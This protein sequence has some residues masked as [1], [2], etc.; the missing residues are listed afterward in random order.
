MILKILTNWK[1]DVIGFSWESN[2][3]AAVLYNIDLIC[4]TDA[5]VDEN[6]W[7]EESTGGE[8]DTSTCLEVDN[9]T[10]AC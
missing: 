9:L 10:S 1:V 2:A 4:R 7:G 5:A 8:D 3:C 6:S